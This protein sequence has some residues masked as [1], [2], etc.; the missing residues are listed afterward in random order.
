MGSFLAVFQGF[1]LYF[2]LISK[3]SCLQNF[4]NNYFVE[5]ISMATSVTVNLIHFFIA[6]FDPVWCGIIAHHYGE[7]RFWRVVDDVKH[8]THDHAFFMKILEKRL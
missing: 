3:F 7:Y 2:K 4:H 1:Y 6:R 5:E 8:F